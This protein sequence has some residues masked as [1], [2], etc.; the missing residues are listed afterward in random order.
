MFLLKVANK[1]KELAIP[2]ALVGGYAVALHGAIRGTVDV[3][4]ITQWRLD[5]LLNIE[6]A[7]YELG[8]QPLQPITAK[9][10]F[11][12]KKLL[13]ND[14]NLIAWNFIN[15]ANPLEQLDIIITYDLNV[16]DIKKVTIN[17][18]VINVLV[19]EK[20]IEMKL[21]S[22]RE[23]DLIDVETLRKLNES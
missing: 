13:I 17:G 8:L 7:M 6:K 4:C 11:N 16:A 1:F 15:H 23:Q 12:N 2:Y 22:G 20:L 18:T 21:A 14:K 5:N 9:Y 10:L 3:D 19:K